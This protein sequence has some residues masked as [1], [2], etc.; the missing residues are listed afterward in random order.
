M[1][2]KI[3]KL[4]PYIGEKVYLRAL[5]MSDLDSI[6]E[7]WNTYESRIGLGR[8]IPNSRTDR[9]EWIRKNVEDMKQQYSFTFAIINKENEEFLGVCA[10]KR[11][12]KINKNAFMS[13]AIYNPKNHGKGFGTDTVKCLLNIGFDTL[14]LHRIEL[15]VY[16]FLKSA[17]HVYEKLGFKH[18]GTRR[19]A[20]YIAGMYVDDLIMDI[21]EHEYREKVSSEETSLS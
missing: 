7:H 5:E 9:Q 15:H 11:V 6:M 20:S 3:N 16:D 21:I 14:N 13:V 2:S 10:L 18:T 4:S 8:Y 12:D 1:S 17:I 19:K